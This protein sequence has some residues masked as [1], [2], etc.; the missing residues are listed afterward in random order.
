MA[1]RGGAPGAE[2]IAGI[3]R[4]MR[5]D[6]PDPAEHAE[7]V[8]RMVEYFGMLDEAG[9]EGAGWGGGTARLGDLREDE[10]VPHE[11]EGGLG[12]HVRTVRR[13]GGTYVAAPGSGGA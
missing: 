4:L 5:L 13:G 2:E 7:K 1:G 3:A 11:W 12:A 6:V 10:H 8:G 9:A